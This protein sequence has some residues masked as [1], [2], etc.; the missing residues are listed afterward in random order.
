VL[1]CAHEKGLADRL[2]LVPTA[3]STDPSLGEDNPLRQIPAL[4]TDDGLALFDSPVICDYLEMLVVA[5]VLVPTGPVA[6]LL[7]LRLQALGDGIADAAV[8]RR[9]ESLRPQG[10]QSPGHLAKLAARVTSGLDWLEAHADELGP[11]PDI[12]RI[13]VACAL[14][15][16]DFRFPSEDWRSGRSRLA[17]WAT[18]FGERPSM[19]AT[20]PQAP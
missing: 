6:R 18:L 13:A 1:V 5:P 3:P 16:L 2:E 8:A 7:A 14:G 12:G 9:G 17:A 20:L 15:Y 4:I 10:E 11:E 19:Q